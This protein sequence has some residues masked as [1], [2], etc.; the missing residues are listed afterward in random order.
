MLNPGWISAA[1][2]VNTP[3]PRVVLSLEVFFC[4]TFKNLMA[5]LNV[6]NIIKF[7]YFGLQLHLESRSG[8]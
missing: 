7:L 5:A 2:L 4:H 6:Q 3:N 8:G 1:H